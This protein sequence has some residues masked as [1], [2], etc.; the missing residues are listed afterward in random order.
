MFLAQ[1][2]VT[3]GDTSVIPTP[4]TN[5]ACNRHFS[6]IIPIFWRLILK[7]TENGNRSSGLSPVAGPALPRE[8][9]GSL[10]GHS[11]ASGRQT[12]AQL[13][14]AKGSDNLT[15]LNADGTQRSEN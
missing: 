9:L 14:L 4:F 15:S 1:A 2:S 6:A 3:G 13:A 10:L 7:G 5:I 11:R 12:A 8:A